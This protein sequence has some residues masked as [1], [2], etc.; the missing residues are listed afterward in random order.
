MGGAAV[1]LRERG[2]ACMQ[3]H[4]VSL[5]SENVW[6]EG[7]V[8]RPLW[9]TKRAAAGTGTLPRAATYVRISFLCQTCEQQLYCTRSKGIYRGPTLTSVEVVVD[10][11]LIFLPLDKL[12]SIGGTNC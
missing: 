9:P 8:D 4:D 7:S 11:G 3:S 5:V 12:S 6:R 10:S 2:A 1:L